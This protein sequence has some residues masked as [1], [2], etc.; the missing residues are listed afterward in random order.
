MTKSWLSFKSYMESRNDSFCCQ[1]VQHWSIMLFSINSLSFN[2]KTYESFFFNFVNRVRMVFT[3][4]CYSQFGQCVAICVVTFTGWSRS[5]ICGVISHRCEV[6]PWLTIW[7]VPFTITSHF[8]YITQFC[9]FIIV[10]NNA[11][12]YVSYH[13]NN[14]IF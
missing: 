2:F 4:V 5:R 12:L 6:M 13:L 1:F 14:S 8:T 11:E 10:I 7:F 9:S 3:R